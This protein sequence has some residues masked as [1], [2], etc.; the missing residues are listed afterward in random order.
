MDCHATTLFTVSLYSAKVWNRGFNWP[1][2]SVRMHKK[3]PNACINKFVMLHV[4]N[5]W[6][7]INWEST[8]IYVK[9]FLLLLLLWGVALVDIVW[10]LVVMSTNLYLCFIS[11]LDGLGVLVFKVKWILARLQV[12]PF[13]FSLNVFDI[14]QYIMKLMALVVCTYFVMLK[15]LNFSTIL[16][17]MTC[18]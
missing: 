7:N 8:W 10:S 14:M 11:S 18:E 16:T 15:Y 17:P 3:S 2:F 6:N 13:R 9:Q 1:V 4:L 5:M 12:H